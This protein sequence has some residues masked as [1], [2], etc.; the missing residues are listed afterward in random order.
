LE[1]QA[2]GTPVIAFGKGGALETVRDIDHDKPTGLF[3]PE[4]TTAAIIQAVR[5][6]E[7]NQHCFTVE[8]CIANA[9]RFSP[10][11]F[12]NTFKQYV[13]KKTSTLTV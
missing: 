3:F 2:C 13:S 11:Q 1:A 9:A 6:F 7:A 8:H 10:E 12:C 5:T 4:Q